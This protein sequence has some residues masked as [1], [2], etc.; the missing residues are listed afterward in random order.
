MLQRR[1]LLLLALVPAILYAAISLAGLG[2]Y[3]TTI[4]DFLSIE[5]PL[6][7]V[8]Q[9]L[10]TAV[11]GLLALRFFFQRPPRLRMQPYLH[12]PMSRWTLVTYFQCGS[13]LSLHN[14]LPLCFLLPFWFTN[15]APVLSPGKAAVWLAGVGAVLLLSH[16]GNIAF[17]L[18]LDRH[19]ATAGLL[20]LLLAA[21]QIIDH[22]LG[23]GWTAMASESMFG[24]LAGGSVVLL[25]VLLL[26]CAGLLI[27][28]TRALHE[29]LKESAGIRE[30]MA[31][32]R[33]R[34]LRFGRGRVR[35]LIIFELLMMLRTKRPKQY[36]FVSIVLAVLYT[37]ILLSD[38]NVVRG[39]V[40]DAFL[41]LFASGAFALNYGQLMFAWESRHFDGLLS[42]DLS[43][44][45]LVMAKMIVLQ[46][47][48]LFMFF[49]CLPLFMW[50]S[51]RLLT[52]HVA[53]LFYNAG[54]T[55][56]LML[57]LAVRNRKRVTTSKGHFFNYQGFSFWH[58]LWLIP[59]VAP[60]AL[61]LTL[62]SNRMGIAVA[63]IAAL[64]LLSMLLV[65][66]WVQWFAR[67]LHENRYTMAAGFRQ[68]TD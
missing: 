4:T 40:M 54:I 21:T 45:Q 41:G 36:A 29:A 31:S 67:R 23:A 42:R 24:T 14:V 63:L 17:R 44:R 12:L 13:L 64:G 3:F 43:P 53:F 39:P 19:L 27:A 8:H 56:I 20:L 22:W 10:L 28:T 55:C 15:V 16:L 6:W 47:S 68:A 26:G 46:L 1:W 11:I 57:T 59:T 32:G 18:L 65:W 7:L 49:L 50:L 5:S 66:P 30:G 37:G 51:P 2:I 62:L 58:W 35:S 52:V 25:G 38:Y 33:R 60:P 9:Y 48:C 34:L 61:I